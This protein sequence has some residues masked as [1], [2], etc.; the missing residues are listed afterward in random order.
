MPTVLPV[1]E[2]TCQLKVHV[3]LCSK[4]MALLNFMYSVT[5]GFKESRTGKEKPYLLWA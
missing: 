3:M 4:W 5:H 2:L 1:S